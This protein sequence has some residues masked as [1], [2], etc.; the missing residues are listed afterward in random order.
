MKYEG[1]GL[2]VHR[3]DYLG[4]IVMNGVPNEQGIVSVRIVG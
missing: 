2:T 4:H 3:V 1:N